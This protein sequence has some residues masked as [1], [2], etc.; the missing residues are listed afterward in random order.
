MASYRRRGAHAAKTAGPSATPGSAPPPAAGGGARVSGGAGGK[1]VAGL[2]TRPS[3]AKVIVAVLVVGFGAMG[4]QGGLWSTPSAE[5]TVQAFLLAWQ[6]NQYEAAAALTTGDPAVVADA[7][8]GA[9]T[10]LDAAAFYLTMGPITQ[11]GATADATFNASVDLGQDG[12]PWNYQGRLRLRRAGGD[13][14]VIWSPSVIHPALRR[15]LRLA[16]LSTTPARGL[17]LDRSGVALQTP[18]AAYVAGVRPD[19]LRDPSATA[20][21]LGHITGLDPSQLL[22][23]ILAAPSSGFQELVVFRPAQY[24]RREK[25]LQRVPGLI[26]RKETRRLFT[27]IA[28]GLVGAVGTEVSPALHDQGIAYRPGTTV[29]LSGLQQAYQRQLAGTPSVEV[30]TETPAG[31]HISKPLARWPGRPATSLRTALDARVQRAADHAVNAARASAAVVAVQASTGHIL[32]VARNHRPGLPDVAPLAGNYPPGTAFTIVSTQA[33]LAHGLRVDTQVRCPSVFDVGG[34]IFRNE[35][36]VAGFGSRP[37]FTA[38]FAHACATAFSGLSRRLAARDLNSVAARFGLGA[39]WRLHLR[40]FSGSVQASAGVAQ[41]AAD[42]IGRG[43]VRVSPLAMAL[44]A[45][46]VDSGTWHAPVLVPDSGGS[47]GGKPEQ[48][49]QPAFSAASL[50]TLRALMRSAART[51]GAAAADRPGLR[52]AGQVGA[53]PLTLGGHRVWATWFVGYQGDVALAVLEFTHSP[54]TSAVP[55]ATSFLAGLPPH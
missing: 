40:S 31:T 45:G 44:V 20:S 15:G 5:P 50:T 3:L 43:S 8:R 27:S 28:P 35:P 48:A 47:Q 39:G 49:P 41:L 10:Q 29:G 1:R 24:A 21:A 51:N 12:A 9:Y 14:K 36:A 37:R 34:R 6:E 18:S 23:W 46:Q 26:I 22:G 25:A 19:R 33:L 32:A 38:D 11:H 16:V 42:T 17:V 54:S 30:V 4:F 7:L 55:L 2:R 53:V 13:W 52:V